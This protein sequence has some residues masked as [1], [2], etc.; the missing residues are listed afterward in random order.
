MAVEI[1]DKLCEGAGE[2]HLVISDSLDT[3]TTSSRQH[4]L[5]NFGDMSSSSRGG[6]LCEVNSHKSAFEAML[7]ASADSRSAH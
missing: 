2:D 1:T 4:L 7:D 6:P 5:P 3:A